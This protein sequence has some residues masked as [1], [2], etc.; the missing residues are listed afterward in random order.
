VE[1]QCYGGA[2]DWIEPGTTKCLVDHFLF[3]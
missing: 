2:N 1:Y 3:F